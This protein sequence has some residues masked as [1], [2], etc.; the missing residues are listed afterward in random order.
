RHALADH[1]LID[2]ADYK[3]VP[4][5]PG[6][7]LVSHEANIYTDQGEGRLGLLYFRKQPFAGAATF[8]E[9]LRAT[10]RDALEACNLLEEEPALHGRVRFRTDEL[11]FRVY[12]RLLA[13]NTDETFAEVK[14]ELEAFLSE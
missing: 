11:L 3:H 4:E 2:V 6:T 7:V 13:P 9:R 12:D 8:A 14:P 1:L 10:F 5:G